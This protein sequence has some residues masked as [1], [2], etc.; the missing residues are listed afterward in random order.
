LYALR[1]LLRGNAAAFVWLGAALF[2]AAVSSWAWYGIWVLPLI[3]VPA[4]PL[5]IGLRASTLTVAY[6][7]YFDATIPT[8]IHLSQVNTVVKVVPLVLA[9][10]YGAWANA[11]TRAR[12]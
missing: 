10:G 1:D 12:R 2:V 4:G 5:A 8:K 6:R 11:R 9:A 3:A 7:Y